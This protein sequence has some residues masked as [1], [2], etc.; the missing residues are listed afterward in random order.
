[1]KRALPSRGGAARPAPPNV[2]RIVSLAMILILAVILFRL[3]TGRE[4]PYESIAREVT[5]ALAANDLA[6]VEK[7]QNAETATQVNR[8]RVGRAADAL[9]PLGKLNEVKQTAADAETRVGRFELTFEHGTL[10]ETIKF[11]PEKKIVSFHYDPPQ[12]VK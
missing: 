5:Q 10:H 12:V 8:G 4:N 7:Y 9:A 1:M 6:A 11:D 2:R 3:V